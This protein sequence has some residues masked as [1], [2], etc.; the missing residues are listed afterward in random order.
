MDVDELLNR[1]KVEVAELG[2]VPANRREHQ[3]WVEERRGAVVLL[4]ALADHDGQ[5]LRSAATGEWV[6]ITVRDLLL[7]AIDECRHR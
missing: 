4:A 2:P 1:A 5:L 7:A 6:S 3:L